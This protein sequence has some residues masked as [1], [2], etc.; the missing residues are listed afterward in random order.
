MR[1]RLVVF[2]AILMLLPGPFSAAQED[3]QQKSSCAALRISN[4]TAYMQLQLLAIEVLDTLRPITDQLAERDFE[5]AVETVSGT[6]D[7]VFAY[8]LDGRPLCHELLEMTI[9]IFQFADTYTLWIMALESFPT[10]TA[11][12][13]QEIMEAPTNAAYER[14]TKAT[15]DFFNTLENVKF[16]KD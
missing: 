7:V 10:G 8:V 11:G 13:V 3:A 4:S 5:N 6:R 1:I 15:N 12:F 14:Y 2:V 9:A 16:S